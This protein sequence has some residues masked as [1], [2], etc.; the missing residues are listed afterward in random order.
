[1]NNNNLTFPVIIQARLSSER[2]PNKVLEKINGKPLIEY[3]IN[4]INTTFK[5][6]RILLATS[7]EKNDDPLI[8][9]CKKNKV[10]YFRGSLNNVAKRLYDAANELNAKSFVRISGDSPLIDSEIILKGIKYFQKGN[11]D[12]V[13]NIFPR[14]YPVG[15]SVEIIKTNSL[16]L[17][18]SRK[19]N[20]SEKE[21]VTKYFYDHSNEFNVFNFLNDEDLSD[22]RLVVDTKLDFNK[23]KKIINKMVYPHTKYSMNEIIYS[24]YEK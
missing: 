7:N 23:M 5:R 4:R 17:I 12:L 1:L 18:L 16:E 3:L 24:L 6:N 11:Y 15:Q 14:S 10:R 8:D 19:M 20:S 9:F 21:H 13:T 22:Y 2:L